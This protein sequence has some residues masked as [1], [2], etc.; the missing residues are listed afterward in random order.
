MTLQERK[1]IKTGDV[2]VI[3]EGGYYDIQSGT[4]VL[5]TRVSEEHGSLFL[6]VI[7]SNNK[8][9]VSKPIGFWGMNNEDRIRNI[10]VL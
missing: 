1:A 3:G 5:V 4:M 8:D 2:L 10:K 6:K 9:K 7:N